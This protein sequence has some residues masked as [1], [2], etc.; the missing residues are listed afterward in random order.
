MDIPLA[1]H[2]IYTILDGVRD[3]FGTTC[4]QVA[5]SALNP[6]MK[7]E[8]VQSAASSGG[9][10][11][12]A[13]YLELLGRDTL[14]PSRFGIL[15]VAT[16][17]IA[18]ASESEFPID[19]DPLIRL[20]VIISQ[21]EMRPETTQRLVAWLMLRSLHA[22]PAGV[23]VMMLLIAN[24]R[25]HFAAPPAS[26]FLTEA[27]FRICTTTRDQHGDFMSKLRLATEANP[28][29]IC[30]SPI[31]SFRLIVQHAKKQDE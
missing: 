1:T 18:L 28:L 21:S 31:N 26:D 2:G 3:D 5:V 12:V 4:C 6:S 22:H 15:P 14:S 8:D 17:A 7:H 9:L 24:I 20:L 23:I 25:H 16:V 29:G 10:S 13:D 30:F 11:A 27:W 19:S